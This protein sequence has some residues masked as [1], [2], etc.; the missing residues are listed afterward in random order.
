MKYNFDVVTDRRGTGAVKWDVGENELPMWVADMDFRTAP[1]VLEAVERKAAHGIFGYQGITKEWYRA[2]AGWW[3]RRHAFRLEE[4]WLMFCT[5]VVPAISS[6][7][8]KLTTPAEKV[9]IQSPV[10][11]V[12]FHSV[13]DNG[14]QVSDS[15]LKYEGGSYE[16]DFGDLEEKLSDPQT[17]MMILCNPHNP[18]GRIWSREELARIGELCAKHH[19]LVISDEIHCDLADPG[20][21]YVPFASVSDTCRENSITCIAPTKTFN[22]AGLQTA[23]VFV[24]DEALRHRVHRALDTDGITGANSFA[25]DAAVAAFTEGDEWLDELREYVFRNKETVRQFLASELPQIRAVPSQATYLLWL[26]CR[27]LTGDAEEF[28]QFL[29]KHTGLFVS[30][31]SSFG[32]DGRHFLRVNLACPRSLVLDGLQRLKEGT[33]AYQ[34]SARLQRADHPLHSTD[35]AIK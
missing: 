9:L 30:S 1:A 20:C 35:S 18:V 27:A 4:D 13:Q 16:I 19:V 10:Y 8:R 29:R 17:T 6:I 11:H 26:D 22:L 3:E 31:G 7:V 33:D 2:Y 5:G 12:F 14:R 23:A 32:G 15:A 28:A 34:A 25:V 24:P 21:G